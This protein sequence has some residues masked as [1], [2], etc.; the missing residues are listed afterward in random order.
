MNNFSPLPSVTLPAQRRAAARQLLEMVVPQW[1]DQK[2]RRRRRLAVA[3][4]GAAAAL[5][6]SA[7]AFAYV[8]QSQPVTNKGE[9]RC[10]TVAS[11]SG[12]DQFHGTTIAA[13]GRPGSTAQVNQAVSVCAALWRQ[14]ILVTGA[15]TAGSPRS[16][17]ADRL[18]PPLV[19]CVMPDG[20][21]AVFPG[22]SQTCASLR[23]PQARG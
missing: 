18:V 16:G 17:T 15:A 6:T 22:N 9:A 2:R 12:G 5:C 21:A 11:L 8:Q 10:Y 1:P 20:T 13:A 14:G 3:G 4:A 7:G 23:L 19:A